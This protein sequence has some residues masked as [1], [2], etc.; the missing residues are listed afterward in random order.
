M[1][2]Y[3]VTTDIRLVSNADT[4]SDF[5]VNPSVPAGIEAVTR[6]QSIRRWHMI[7]TT[8]A[9]SVGEHSANVGLLAYYI[10][11]TVPLP[12]FG[13]PEDVLAGAML[14]DIAEVFMG[15]IPTHTKKC[16]GWVDVL[17]ESLVPPVFKRCVTEDVEL[18]IKICDLADGIRFIEHFGVSQAAIRAMDG[19][20]DLLDAKFKE[21]QGRWPRDVFDSAFETVQTYLSE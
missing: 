14:H 17:E 4:K 21:A 12:C 7:D 2:D 11:K 20:R 9:Q 15:D 3:R 8:R 19:L 6:F 5:R 1:S 18:L 13:R 10:A 16:L